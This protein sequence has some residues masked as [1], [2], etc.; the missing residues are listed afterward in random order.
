MQQFEDWVTETSICS[1]SGWNSGAELGGCQGGHCPPKILPG[2]PSGLPKIFQVSFWKSYT[3]HWQLPLLQN[4]PLQWPPQMKMSGSAP[5]GTIFALWLNT[6]SSEWEVLMKVRPLL[7]NSRHRAKITPV[8]IALEWELSIVWEC[9]PMLY[10]VWQACPTFLVLRAT[11][12]L[13]T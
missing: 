11:K 1:Q 8:R 3:D 4:W 10:G 12:V 6:R 7:R 5:V 9:Y 13:V 2:P